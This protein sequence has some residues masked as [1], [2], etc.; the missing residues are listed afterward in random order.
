MPQVC[1]RRLLTRIHRYTQDRLRRE[2]EPVSARDFIRFLLRWQHV[3]P[4]TQREGRRG[5][6]AVIEQL[7][8][9]ESAAG[10]WEEKLFPARVDGY[11]SAWLDEL[12]LSGNVSWGRL[13]LQVAN[14][15]SG[16]TRR[17]VVP[18]RATPVSFLL[19]ADLL[20]LLEASRGE[21]TPTEPGPGAAREILDCLRKQGA[22]FPSELVH[23][24]ARLPIEVEEGLWD[25][26]SRGLVSADSY[27]AVRSLFASRRRRVASAERPGR[28]RRL[29]RGSSVDLR[30]GGRWALLPGPSGELE[31]DSLAE[32]VAEQLLA[33]WGV[34]FRDLLARESLSLAWR[35]LL[36]AFRRMEARGTIR[37][38]RFV[39]GFVGEQYALPGA[40]DALRRVRRMER[41]GEVLRLSAADP[42]NLV[43]I[44][45]PGP[46]I[47]ALRGRTVTYQ[48]GLPIS[49]EESASSRAG[50]GER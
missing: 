36:W 24:T 3:A 25:L 22:L 8:G 39:S 28:P 14:S 9:F 26:V 29:R 20:W 45:T 30:G 27:Q 10:S 19:R 23:A 7:Q 12:C 47:P 13:S 21:T 15:G 50:G 48:D 34:V 17:G 43:G 2:I 6:L 11:R 16:A 33:R 31:P 38:G 4:A 46:R 40:V 41:R 35:D 49:A 37:G 18:S 32:A 5:L 42:L 44:L 1:A